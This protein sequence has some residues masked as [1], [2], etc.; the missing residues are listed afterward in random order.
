[1]A[2]HCKRDQDSE[3]P[4][5]ILLVDDHPMIQEGLKQLIA[6]QPDLELCG[7]A[8]TGRE[9]LEQAAQLRPDLAIVDLSLE[10][11]DGLDL[12]RDLTGRNPGLA[13]L[14]LS[15]RDERFYAERA[16]RAGAR[17]YV[18]KGRRPRTVMAAI[19][20]VLDGQVYLSE[21][22]ASRLL[23]RVVHEAPP[24]DSS[25]VDSLSDRELEV[26]SLIGQGLGPSKIAQRL[27]LSVKTIETYRSHIKRKLKLEDAAALR[28]CAIQWARPGSAD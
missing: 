8:T 23:R 22:M 28:Q 1:M 3:S 9:A 4:S 18:P 26:F 13:I 17:G 25:P 20:A 14:V 5:R 11:M 16:L 27:H 6:K 7:A 2:K 24:E 10:D 15:M 21:K 19:R 12:I